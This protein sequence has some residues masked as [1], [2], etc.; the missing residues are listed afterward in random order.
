MSEFIDKVSTAEKIR[1]TKAINS[2]FF[3][4]MIESEQREAV[5]PII[6]HRHFGGFR[7]YTGFDDYGEKRTITV[8]ER[9]ECDVL[10]CPSCQAMLCSRFQ[11]YCP[12]CGEKIQ[13]DDIIQTGTC[14]ECG[15]SDI[16]RESDGNIRC[17]RWHI[18]V[19][20]DNKRQ[21]FH[22]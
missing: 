2:A 10:C 14:F 9:Y 12:R 21:C 19:S 16:E 15:D 6:K 17:K 8:D 3:A 7:R 4:N 13:T 5:K 22:K 18:W 1:S 20:C 11:N